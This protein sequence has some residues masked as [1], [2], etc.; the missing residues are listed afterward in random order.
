[1]LSRQGIVARENGAMKNSPAAEPAPNPAEVRLA[2]LEERQDDT[3]ALVQHMERQIAN[4][5]DDP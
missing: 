1:M 5:P 2:E 4:L 3:R